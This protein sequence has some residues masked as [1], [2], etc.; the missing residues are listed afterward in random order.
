M[1][2]ELAK[3]YCPIQ[4]ELGAFECREFA[5]KHLI[6]KDV[7]VFLKK[8]EGLNIQGSIVRFSDNKDIET[9]MVENGYGFVKEELKGTMLSGKL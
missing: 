1:K 8:D 5:R 4:G 6:G 7:N 2:I 3:I 9:L